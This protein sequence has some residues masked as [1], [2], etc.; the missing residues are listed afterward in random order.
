MMGISAL[1]TPKL[2]VEE[3][4]TLDRAAE[5][6]SEYHDGEML[7]VATTSW[8]HSVISIN[9]AA[10]LRT[11]LRGTPCQVAGSSLRLRVSPTKFIVP[12]LIIVCGKPA[13]TDEFQDTLTNPKV[14]IEILS[15]STADYDYGRKFLLYRRLPSFE[16]Y[17]LISQDQ[18]RVEV[19]RKTS[20]DHWTLSTVRGLGGVVALQ[21]VGV[22]LALADVYE[23]V[24]LPPIA[25]D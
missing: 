20:E 1:L 12:D 10:L 21:T 13:L 22:S 4:L 8:K 11:A 19:Y 24:D 7:P 15:P 18:A 17:I 25:E 6:P 23:S 5:E 2:S 9:V 16:E 14:V 3:Y